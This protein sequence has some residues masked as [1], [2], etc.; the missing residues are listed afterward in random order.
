MKNKVVKFLASVMVVSSLLTGCGGA[1]TPDGTYE[2]GGVSFNFGKDT[3]IVTEGSA[4]VTCDY[5]MNSEGTIT[6][7]L[8]GDELTC[9]YDEE[10]D[11]INF[12]GEQYTK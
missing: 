2:N 10:H 6:F 8:E 11:V 9:T 1:K 7:E 5:K 3:V 4:N 12:D